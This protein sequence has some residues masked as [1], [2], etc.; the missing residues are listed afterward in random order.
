LRNYLH[1]VVI[2]PLDI[3]IKDRDRLLF[4]VT[5][6]SGSTYLGKKIVITA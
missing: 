5:G 6:I 4:T 1:K 2:T 3:Q